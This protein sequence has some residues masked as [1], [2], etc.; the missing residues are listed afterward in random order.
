MKETVNKLGSQLLDTC[1]HGLEINAASCITNKA[2]KAVAC[3]L[4]ILV[5]II[6]T[7]WTVT[8][9]K[10]V[11]KPWQTRTPG[12]GQASRSEPSHQYYSILLSTTG[13]FLPDGRI[14]QHSPVQSSVQ[15][16]PGNPSLPPSIRP[17]M[18]PSCPQSRYCLSS[19]IKL[20]YTTGC[21]ASPYLISSH[22][23]ALPSR[24]LVSCPRQERGGIWKDKELKIETN[25]SCTRLNTSCT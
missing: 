10:Q 8:A 18:H 7:T 22:V 19:G 1:R 3:L 21:L 4:C 25:Q 20:V 6:S 12:N 13:P 9:T 14:Y 5:G 2:G 24:E 17:F 23:Q 11:C 16:W 15:L